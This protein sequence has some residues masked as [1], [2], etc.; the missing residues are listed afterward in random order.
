MPWFTPGQFSSQCLS[1]HREAIK[2]L[3]SN[4]IVQTQNDFKFVLLGEQFDRPLQTPFQLGRISESI[5][6]PFFKIGFFFF[7][8]WGK[9]LGTIYSIWPRKERG[10]WDLFMSVWKIKAFKF[11]ARYTKRCLQKMER[12]SV[13]IV[14]VRLWQTA[15]KGAFQIIYFSGAWSPWTR[16][17]RWV[18]GQQHNSFLSWQP[19]K[20]F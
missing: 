14:N 12:M 5:S 8:W 10:S 2:F 20:A 16:E 11:S 19:F 9:G 18:T 3:G 15:L 6:F 1:R 17:R 4:H 7:S 13:S